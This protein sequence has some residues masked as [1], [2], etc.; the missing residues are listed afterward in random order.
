MNFQYKK[1]RSQPSA[2]PTRISKVEH[3]KLNRRSRGRLGD[4]LF[5]LRFSMEI[6][7]I[8]KQMFYCLWWIIENLKITPLPRSKPPKNPP[9]PTPSLTSR[10]N[11]RA[12]QSIWKTARTRSW[13]AWTLP[14]DKNGRRRVLGPRVVR[15]RSSAK[16]WTP[17]LIT[18]S[19][20]K[21]SSTSAV[22]IVKCWPMMR[23]VCGSLNNLKVSVGWTNV[24]QWH[25]QFYKTLF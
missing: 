23:S 9:P 25:I 1:H 16:S 24:T 4:L 3:L 6:F 18:P 20:C 12:S 10:A 8:W 13:S 14:N 7:A 22:T 5:F 11:S 21:T 15:W 19:N 17:L 2:R